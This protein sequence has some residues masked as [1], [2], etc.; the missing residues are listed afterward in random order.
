MGF[1]EEAEEAEWNVMKIWYRAVCDK[2]GE[3]IYVMVSNPSCS[4]SLLGRDDRA[5]QAWLSAHCNCE[6]RLV[7]RD[8]QTDE[9]WKNGYRRVTVDGI[10]VLKRN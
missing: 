3:A 10:T 9:L 1:V 4:A 5:I 6:L 8:D 2:C 7:W